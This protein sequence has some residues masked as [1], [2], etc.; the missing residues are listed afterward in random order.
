L[1]LALDAA[2]GTVFSLEAFENVGVVDEAGNAVASQT[3][4]GLE[5][6]PVSD[7]SELWKTFSSCRT[8]VASFLGNNL[9]QCAI[10]TIGL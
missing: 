10:S 9:K 2:P 7:R 3:K 4:S 8:A 6:N 1:D 5:S